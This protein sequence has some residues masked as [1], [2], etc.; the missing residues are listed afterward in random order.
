MYTLMTITNRH[1]LLPG[2]RLLQVIHR[3][4][5]LAV[6]AVMLVALCLH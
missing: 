6:S 2:Q 1:Q 5:A 3:S 4:G